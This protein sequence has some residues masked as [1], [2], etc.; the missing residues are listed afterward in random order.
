MTAG[1]YVL[2]LDSAGAPPSHSEYGVDTQP[3]LQQRAWFTRNAFNIRE[4]SDASSGEC[5]QINVPEP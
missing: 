1:G 5:D 4:A 2:T 3:F